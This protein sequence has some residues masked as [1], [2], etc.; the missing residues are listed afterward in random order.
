MDIRDKAISQANLF[1]TA[2]GIRDSTTTRELGNVDKEQI[3][4]SNRLYR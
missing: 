1:R 4:L 3:E 2:D